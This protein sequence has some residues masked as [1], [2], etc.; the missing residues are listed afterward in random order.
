MKKNLTKKF[1]WSSKFHLTL[2]VLFLCFSVSVQTAVAQSGT[3]T[4][5]VLDSSNQPLIGA[6]ILENGTTNGASAGASG[7]FSIKVKLGAKL[8]ISY[9][10]YLS[11]EVLVGT[12]TNMDIILEADAQSIEAVVAIG[13]GSQRKEDLSMSV[14]TLKVDDAM[15]GRPQ[16]LATILQGRIPGVT[17][18]KSG[19]PM[20]KSS[21]SI[22]GRGS[23]G[24]DD[25]PTS[26]DGVLFVVDG[27][28]N[29]P[30]MVSDIE[31]I[32]VL[33]D[34][35]SAAIYGASVGSS[36]VILI[37]TRK[38][39][40]GQIRVSANVSIGLQN[41]INLPTVTT[42][43]EYNSVWAMA[44]KNSPGS[45]LP[46]AANPELYPWGNV[47]RTDWLDEIFN[48]ALTQHYDVSISGGTETMQSVFSVSYDNSEGVLLNTHSQALNAKLQ[49]TYK[50]AD[51]FKITERASFQHTNG[52]GDVNTSHE[53]PIMGALWYPSSASVYELNEDGSPVYNEDGSQ[54][55]GGTSPRWASAAGYPNIFNPVADLERMQQ[56]NPATKIFSTTSFE[57]KPLRTLSVKS[58]FTVDMY[59]AETDSFNAKMEEPG[60]QRKENKRTQRFYNNNHWLWETTAAWA[61]EFNGHHISAMLGYTMDYKK[62]QY[63]QIRT[64]NYPLEFENN[65]TWDSA[66][67][68]DG[69]P[70][71][72]INEYS[73]ISALAR[74]GYSYNDRYF[75]VGSLRRDASSKLPIND[76]SDYFPAVSGSWKIS[77]ESFFKNSSI[78]NTV[79]LFK[80]RGSWGKVGNVD[81]YD[82]SATN[83]PMSTKDWPIIWGE[84]L[85]QNIYGQYLATIP[86]FNA[87][88]EV[89]EQSGVG[90][91]LTMFDNKLDF[92]VDYY[93]K[94]TKDLVDGIPLPPQYGISQSPIGNVGQV[95]NRGFEV[96]VNYKGAA[97]NFNYNVWGMFNTNK[98]WVREY[99]DLDKPIEHRNPNLNSNS[100][101]YS[102]VDQ[103]WHSFRLYET[104]GIFRSEEEV[105]NH[106]NSGGK[107]IQPDA[108]PGDLIFVDNNGD[109]TITDDDREFMGSYAPVNTFSFGG[110]IDYKGFDL[111]LM[112]QGVSGNY[113]YNGLKQM[114]MNGRE[115]GGNLVTDVLDTWDFNNATSEYPRLG[116]VDDAN[117]NYTRFSDVFLEKGDYLRLKNVTIGYTLPSK[118]AKY[119]GLGTGAIRVYAS[120]DNAFTITGYS[121]IDPEVGNYGVDRGVYPL[122]RMYNFGVNI[123]F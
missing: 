110:S 51:W 40:V 66:G 78:A 16:D 109:G 105:L 67:E 29:A 48:S 74:V 20:S 12:Q 25:D 14:S 36:G 38:A 26:G 103:P 101:L 33:K 112:F 85:D 19:D 41:A 31:T 53:G 35:A 8:T 88:W 28:P 30:Y 73:M 1:R 117:G 50:V 87:R 76:N 23:K 22:R 118:I 55:Y 62:L 58:D 63:R 114:G 46:S 47:Q 45:T 102:Y 43:P 84:N 71:E 83:I 65:L 108:Q 100:L 68:V 79:D 42:A 99:G 9:L 92:T 4:G 64:K 72:S 69:K 91:D 57:F 24:N 95:V 94:V 121:G 90:L 5:R 115:Q 98:G 60:L 107:L 10:G 59:T 15:K 122:T 17:V 75:F 116:L 86:N 80:I 18:A 3:I 52:Q 96:S 39:Q 2:I 123:N 111:S 104:A 120:I 54:M 6:T 11:K 56:N 81:L 106:R 113:V 97:R 32:T 61:E 93:Y 77:S 44:V 119:V 37:T 34:A 27:V 13:Y 89:T 70:G 82:A 7:D 21:F 49:T